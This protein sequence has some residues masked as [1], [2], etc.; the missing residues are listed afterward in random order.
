M[1]NE[2]VM[3]EEE[4]EERI[5]V[6]KVSKASAK[7]KSTEGVFERRARAQSQAKQDEVGHDEEDDDDDDVRVLWRALN[8]TP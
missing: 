6:P 4:E 2:E 1:S 8:R 3:E 5:A 7:R